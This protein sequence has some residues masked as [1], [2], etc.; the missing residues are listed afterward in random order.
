LDWINDQSINEVEEN[1]RKV[2]VKGFLLFLGEFGIEVGKVADN[3][4]VIIILVASSQSKGWALKSA[5]QRDSLGAD[6]KTAREIGW[7]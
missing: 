7:R 2:D 3:S 4:W 5:L 6:A 1:P